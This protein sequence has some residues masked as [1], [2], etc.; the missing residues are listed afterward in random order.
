M[1]AREF[2]Y[3][4]MKVQNERYYGNKSKKW[5][6][7]VCKLWMN[8]E[9]DAKW[10]YDLMV[11]FIDKEKLG[12]LRILDMA[13]GCGTFVFYGLTKGFDVYGI[14]P[15]SW[16][17]QFN[18]L[19]AEEKGY[20]QKWMG[21]FCYSVGERLPYKNKS[22]DVIYTYQTLEHVQSHKMCFDEF[23]RVLKKGGYLFIGCPDYT[24]FFEGHY[25]I[26]MLPLM[27]KKLF[28]LYL[29]L[30]RKPTK[31]LNSLNY[32]TKKMV[33]YCL[34]DDYEIFDVRLNSAR[35]AIKKKICI[36]SELL[37]CV[38]LI[39]TNLKYVFTQEKSVILVAVKK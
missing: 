2:L 30:L 1:T 33:Y 14:E 12:R 6:D 3:K 13:S 9:L 10:R 25:R 34:N 36:D 21:K 27:N 19:K 4:Q 38:Y 18:S 37:A 29:K 7:Y 23:K 20:P 39:L 24:S 8:D 15:E 5:L 22:F 11:S 26:P 28:V 17:H 16:K 32:I 35:S 31:G